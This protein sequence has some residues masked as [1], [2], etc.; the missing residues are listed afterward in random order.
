LVTVAATRMTTLQADPLPG[1]PIASSTTRE[2]A[3]RSA[4]A[5]RLTPLSHRLTFGFEL[6]ERGPVRYRDQASNR[7]L[8]GI[9][10]S[11]QQRSR[12]QIAGSQ[13]TLSAAM[14]TRGVNR[15]LNQIPPLGQFNC[16]ANATVSTLP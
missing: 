2:R 7:A 14:A 11:E 4:C 9:A 12:V 10:I 5:I 6:I 15:L 1:F 8:K 3:T 16:R 13:P